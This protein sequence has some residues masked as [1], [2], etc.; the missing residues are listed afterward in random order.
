VVKIFLILIGQDDWIRKSLI[1]KQKT[2]NKKRFYLIGFKQDLNMKYG[3][4]DQ[5]AS[6]LSSLY[7]ERK[8]TF[9]AEYLFVYI[10][11]WRKKQRNKKK[12]R[13]KERKM[14]FGAE[15]LFVWCAVCGINISFCIRVLY[16]FS[17]L[18]D[19]S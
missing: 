1:Q 8:M 3:K 15:Y 9:G 4:Q 16:A 14:T 6:F 18:W 12:Q 7:K 19:L 11:I 2:K 17:C 13:K 10:Y 5:R